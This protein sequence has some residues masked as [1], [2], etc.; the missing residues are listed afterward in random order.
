MNRLREMI[1]EGA[2]PPGEWIAEIKLCSDLH[3]SR[4]P[5]REALKVLASEGLVKLVQNR[6]AMVTEVG[7]E[8]IAELFQIMDLGRPSVGGATS[9]AAAAEAARNHSPARCAVGT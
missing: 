2:L 6:G 1:L 3:I 5:L 9:T 8:E 4:T 7:V